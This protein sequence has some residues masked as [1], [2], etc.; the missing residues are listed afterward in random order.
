[1]DHGNEPAAALS[2]GGSVLDEIADQEEYE[3]ESPVYESPVDVVA[4]RHMRELRRGMSIC[5]ESG[6]AGG[7]EERPISVATAYSCTDTI[8][9][10]SLAATRPSCCTFFSATSE[11]A[12][13]ISPVCRGSGRL[14]QGGTS[15]DSPGTMTQRSM[16]AIVQQA[17]IR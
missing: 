16:Y 12:A 7:V 15:T 14:R 6:A 3:Y 4:R 13:L 9:R 5:E 10:G 17:G 8:C 11:E 2:A 1:M